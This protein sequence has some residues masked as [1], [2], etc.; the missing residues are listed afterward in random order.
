MAGR[1]EEAALRLVRAVCCLTGLVGDLAC[2]V[3]SLARQYQFEL[4]PLS[5]RHIANGRGDERLAAVLDRAETDLD[6]KFR[7]ILALGI[8]VAARTHRAGAVL[9]GKGFSVADVAVTEALGQQ[10]LDRAAANFLPLVPE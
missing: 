9:R 7:A 1:G 5:I 4:R 6:R 2:Q 8:E 10:M 3:R